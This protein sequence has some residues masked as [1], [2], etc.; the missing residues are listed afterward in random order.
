MALTH[1][2]KLNWTP[3]AI[4]I[5]EMLA[6]GYQREEAAEEAGVGVA[7]VYRLLKNA[8]FRDELDRLTLMAGYALKAHRVRLAMAVIRQKIDASTG[9]VQTKEDLLDWLKYL[10]SETEGIR[11][12]LSQFFAAISPPNSE[13]AD[14]ESTGVYALSSI[15]DDERLIDPE[16]DF[17]E[18]V[19]DEVSELETGIE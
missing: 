9:T 3:Q 11:L 17:F 7:T 15:D 12:D 1:R 18:L 4:K 8:E 19:E 10:Q 2:G 14:G 16:G 6:Q 13:L 5:V